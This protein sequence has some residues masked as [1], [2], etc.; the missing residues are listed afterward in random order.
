MSEASYVSRASTFGLAGAF[1]VLCAAVYF[2]SQTQLGSRPRPR[3]IEVD[4]LNVE[5]GPTLRFDSG[6]IKSAGAVVG[7]YRLLPASPGKYGPSIE[8]AGIRVRQAGG[9]I[10]IEPGNE[11]WFWRFRNDDVVEIMFYPQN[12]TVAHRCAA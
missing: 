2:A 9:N 5:R 12:R 8:V 3:I 1:V 11:A 4:C 6:L 10:V 7:T